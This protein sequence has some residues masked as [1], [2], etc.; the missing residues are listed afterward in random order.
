MKTKFLCFMQV[1]WVGRREE[2]GEAVLN[3]L[4]LH[5]K[6]TNPEREAQQKKQPN[7]YFLRIPLRNVNILKQL[8][9]LHTLAI[10]CLHLFPQLKRVSR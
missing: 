6:P 9:Y 2:S 7:I 8:F 3:G 4:A 10:D 5:F 1:S